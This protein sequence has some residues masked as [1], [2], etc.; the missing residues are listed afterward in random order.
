[1]GHKVE[2]RMAMWAAK[3]T[4]EEAAELM[5]EGAQE[6]ADLRRKATLTDAERGAVEAAIGWCDDRDGKTIKTMHGLLERL[7]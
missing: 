5:L 6:I 2:D 3:R 1:M 4:R 7:T